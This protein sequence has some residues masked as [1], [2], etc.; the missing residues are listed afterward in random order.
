MPDNVATKSWEKRRA[1]LLFCFLPFPTLSTQ[2]PN[3][4]S[5]LLMDKMESKTYPEFGN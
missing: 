2:P 4:R 3:N 5:L 1:S